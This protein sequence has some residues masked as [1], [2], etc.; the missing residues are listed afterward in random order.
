M[1][2]DTVRL[3]LIVVIAAL[4]GWTAGEAIIAQDRPPEVYVKP[5]L[6]QRTL[7]K[8]PQ[9]VD[10]VHLKLVYPTAPQDGL[11]VGACQ[12]YLGR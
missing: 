3:L 12:V 1:V 7:E 6:E 9:R 11:V 5:R 4:L 8:V 2:K 10:T